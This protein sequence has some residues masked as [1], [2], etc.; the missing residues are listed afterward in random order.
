MGGQAAAVPDIRVTLLGRFAVTVGGVPV[1]DAGWTRRHA[2]AVVK[3]LAPATRRRT[4]QARPSP[5]TAGGA[6]SSRAMLSGSRNDR[7]E[8]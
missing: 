3:V 7:P 4:V 6:N 2:A 1:A 5:A 8:P